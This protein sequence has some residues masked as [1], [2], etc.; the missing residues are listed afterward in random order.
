[1]QHLRLFLRACLR[2]TGH[3]L[4]HC[5]HFLVRLSNLAN[6]LALT[7]AGIYSVSRKCIGTYESAQTV[8]FHICISTTILLGPVLMRAHVCMYARTHTCSSRGW[9]SVGTQVLGFIRGLHESIPRGLSPSASACLALSSRRLASGSF[10]SLRMCP[11]FPT[12]STST[13]VAR[14]AVL[15]VGNKKQAFAD[16]P[17]ARM[18]AA[19]GL[20]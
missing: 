5:R 19:T 3:H 12:E 8:K 13:W 9:K 20:M 17:E 7:C 15:L 11:L 2:D 4:H 16:V 18:H 14:R 1:M 10:L 6:I